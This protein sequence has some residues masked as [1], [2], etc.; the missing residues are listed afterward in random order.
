M[1]SAFLSDM[2]FDVLCRRYWFWLRLI[3]QSVEDHY[4][5]NPLFP[6]VTVVIAVS[7]DN[8]RMK[9]NFLFSGFKINNAFMSK[10]KLFGFYLHKTDDENAIH[11]TTNHKVVELIAA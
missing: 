3:E 7:S 1:H 10:E 2:I 9:I 8:P 6:L 11:N 4:L 5:Q